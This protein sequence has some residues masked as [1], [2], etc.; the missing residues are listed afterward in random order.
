LLNEIEKILEGRAILFVPRSSLNTNIPPRNPAFYNP[1]ATFNRNISIDIYRIYSKEKI[2]P[3]KMGDCFSGVGARG[4]RTGVEVPNISEIYFNDINHFAI[5]L[6]NLSAKENTIL[7]RCHF[8]VENTCKFLMD[9]SAKD[10]RFNI[11]DM[12]PFGSPAPYIDCGLRSISNGGLF[13]IT[14]TDMAV[15]CGVYPQVSYRKYSGLSFRTEYCHEVG[16]RLMLGAV[17]HSALRLNLGI[18]P[19]FAHRTRHYFRVYLTVNIGSKWLDN[20]HYN[21][22]FIHH[23]FICGYRSYKRES[24]EIC[25]ECNSILKNAGPLW[26]G[27]IYNKGFI[28]SILKEFENRKNK[29]I[30]KIAETAYQEI[31]LPPTYYTLDNLSSELKVVTPSL[32]RV[33]SSL[34]D[35]GFLAS[36]TTLNPI[37]IKTDASHSVMLRLVKDLS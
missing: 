28:E 13:S 11:L 6:A 14:A 3:V 34:K 5:S 26:I 31:D 32:D 23:C 21:L 9:H 33:I 15:L 8:S 1:N 27:Q 20:N 10:T 16:I 22:G 12:D 17:A 35:L 29:P 4:I 7:D 36:R 37:G 2:A 30:I 24:L 25:P 18:N 19:I